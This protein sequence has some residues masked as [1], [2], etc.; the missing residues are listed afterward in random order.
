MNSVAVCQVE[1]MPCD[2]HSP[3]AMTGSIR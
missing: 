2:E 1:L 3:P